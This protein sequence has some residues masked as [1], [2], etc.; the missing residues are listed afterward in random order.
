MVISVTGGLER[1]NAFEAVSAMTEV[2][3]SFFDACTQLCPSLE[4]DAEAALLKSGRTLTNTELA[5]YASHYSLWQWLIQSKFSQIIVFEDD[6]T[7]DWRFVE[8]LQAVD[9][10]AKGINFLRLFTKVPPHWCYIKTPFF[11][12]YHHLIRITNSALGG[13]AYLL[14]KQ[15]ADLL[16]EHANPVLVPIDTY[17]DK[18][19]LHGVPNL[20]LYPFHV[21][22]RL[23]ISSIGEARFVRSEL[24]P[25][26]RISYFRNKCKEKL[27]M[28]LNR[29]GWDIQRFKA[30]L[31]Q[32]D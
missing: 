8:K 16:I 2:P 11:D 20:A 26:Q 28:L 5:C 29:S 25:A 24:T 3:W 19:W 30:S 27:Y 10:S 18:Y 15:G 32:L 23:Q 9:F 7:V 31:S 22:E 13:Q 17:M 6:V 12:R 4:Y 21:F 14:T 1:R